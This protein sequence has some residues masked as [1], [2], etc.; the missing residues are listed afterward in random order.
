MPGWPEDCD[1]RFAVRCQRQKHTSDLS[2][3]VWSAIYV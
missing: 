2:T 3:S 1:E